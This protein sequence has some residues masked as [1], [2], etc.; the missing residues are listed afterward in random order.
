MPK[1]GLGTRRLE[2]QQVV[3]SRT[4][5]TAETLAARQ[6]FIAPPARNET[7]N[8]ARVQIRRYQTLTAITCLKGIPY[9]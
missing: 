1:I 6:L 8:T 5:D 9:I 3:N 4:Q 2:E 7:T